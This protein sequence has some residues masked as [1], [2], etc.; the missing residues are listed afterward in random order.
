MCNGVSL[1][2]V[3]VQ[4]PD[5]PPNDKYPIHYVYSPGVTYCGAKTLGINMGGTSATCKECIKIREK[6]I[7]GY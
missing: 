4:V 6:L 7:N 5:C 1:I 2:E 3:K